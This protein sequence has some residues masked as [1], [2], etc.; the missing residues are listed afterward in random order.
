MEGWWV[1]KVKKI[2]SNASPTKRNENI[3]KPHNLQLQTP[4]NCGCENS[5]N[6]VTTEFPK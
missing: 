2:T 6:G 3:T 4:V 1:L 5:I